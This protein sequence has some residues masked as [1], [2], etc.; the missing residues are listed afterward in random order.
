MNAIQYNRFG[1]PE[2]L[3]Y[4]DV[5]VPSPGAGEVLIE[6]TAVGVNFPDIRERLGIY[7]QKETRVG[8]V[9]LPQIGGVQVVGKV[10]DTGSG[11]SADLRGR[12]VMAIMIKGAYAQFA[13]AQEIMTV[14]LAD[15]ADDVVMASLPMQGTTAYLSL[16]ELARI[17]PGDS[18]LVQGAAGG[19]GSL[20]VQ[21]AKALGA[22]FVVGTA[23][24]EE[25]RAFVRDLGADLAIPYDTSEWPQEVL[26]HT[27][28]QGVDI[29]LESIGGN[30]F[31]QNFECLA[32]FGRYVIFGSTR[33]PGEPLAPRR[34][35]TKAQSLIGIYVAVF[36][37]HR[38]QM[39]GESLRFLANGVQSGTIKASVATMLPL[40]RTAEAHRMLEGHRAQGVIVLD[41]RS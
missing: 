13:V 41:P 18:V 15:D 2:V 9:T 40:S 7:N 11:V 34:L 23:S 39:I 25:R 22:G 36:Y 30:V 6:T 16:K 33:G 28:G 5:P 19:V 26:R 32:H 38:P 21:I 37:H 29:I 4:V 17:Q 20:A 8:G 1:G 24:S 27:D 14:T 3:E 35:M 10:V 12:R 31:E